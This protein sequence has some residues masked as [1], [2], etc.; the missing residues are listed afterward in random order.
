ME[1]MK[2]QQWIDAGYSLFAAEGP[3]GLKVEVLA[4]RVGRSKSG[5]YHHFAELDVFRELLLQE[6]VARSRGIA[7]RE[8]TCT[9]LVPDLLE[10]LVEV[11]EDLFFERQ[12]RVHRA[13]PAYRA[14]SERASA[15]TASAMGTIWAAGLGLEERSVLAHMVLE[16]VL[17]NFYLR[18]TPGALNYTWL[19]A[20]VQEVQAMVA[21]STSSN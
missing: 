6:H 14:C 11:Q 15:T 17:D 3:T 5:F 7:E 4:R 1:N 2:R 19:L 8:R 12:L 21:R 10:L 9:R 13:N 16:L 20:Y 18:I